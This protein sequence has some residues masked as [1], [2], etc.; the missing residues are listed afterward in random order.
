MVRKRRKKE[1]LRR[2]N[3]NKPIKKVLM[4]ISKQVAKEGSHE[5]HGTL[6]EV[7]I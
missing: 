3:E 4:S 7:N 6:F 1:T 2:E 5:T